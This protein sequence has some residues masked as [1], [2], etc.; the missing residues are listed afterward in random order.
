MLLYLSLTLIA[1]RDPA[2]VAPAAL[3]SMVGTMHSWAMLM[4]QG[5]QRSEYAEWVHAFRAF[6][7]ALSWCESVPNFPNPAQYKHQ[8]F[9]QLGNTNRRFGRY[10]QARDILEKA[11]EIAL[12]HAFADRYN[13]AKR[14]GHKR[15]RCR[16]VGN[17]GMVD[18]QLAGRSGSPLL[19]VAIEQLTERITSVRRLEATFDPQSSDLRSVSLDRDIFPKL[20]ISRMRKRIRIFV[21]EEFPVAIPKLCLTL[22]ASIFDFHIATQFPTEP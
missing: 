18:Y 9:G 1:E 12:N 16:A 11:L 7:R 8:L 3:A 14:L 2:G 22:S 15:A 10:E 19:D 21:L 6:N 20:R 13:T 17:L 5:W 4:E